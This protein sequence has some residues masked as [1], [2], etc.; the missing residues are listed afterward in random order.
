MTREK[1]SHSLVIPDGTDGNIKIA[2]H[3]VVTVRNIFCSD[4]A[5]ET[6]GKINLASAKIPFPNLTFPEKKGRYS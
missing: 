5:K 2:L 3:I 6:F 4:P 1:Q